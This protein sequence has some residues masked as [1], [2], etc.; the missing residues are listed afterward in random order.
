[1]GAENISDLQTGGGHS[2]CRWRQNLQWTGDD[3]KQVG[4][5]LSIQRV[6]LE[7]VMT[8]QYLYQPD[9][10]LLFEQVGGERMPQQMHRD[11][12]FDLSSSG[13]HGTTGAYLM[14]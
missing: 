7:L 14:S 3:L 6:G 5:H 12:L 9:I 1:V 13:W 2:L 10:D 11:P 8:E 4:G